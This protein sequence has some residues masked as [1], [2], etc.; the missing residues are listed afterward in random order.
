MNKV[1]K[2]ILKKNKKGAWKILTLALLVIS[3]LIIFM[4]TILFI[5]FFAYNKDNSIVNAIVIGVVFSFIV[6]RRCVYIDIYEYIRDGNINIPDYAKDNYYRKMAQNWL[7]TKCET[8]KD[9]TNFR[10]DILD[11]LNPLVKCVDPEEIKDM[12]NYKIQYTCL[13]ILLT[14]ILLIKYDMKKFLPLFLVWFFVVFRI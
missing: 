11:N 8:R 5:V 4:A 3:H 14:I 2:N 7:G 10:L 6:F 13:N 9:L 12:Y 1:T